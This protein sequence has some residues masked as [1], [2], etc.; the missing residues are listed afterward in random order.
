MDDA[1]NR[2]VGSNAQRERQD[3]DAGKY[4]ALAQRA[5]GVEKITPSGFEKA[6]NTSPTGCILS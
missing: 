5:Y 6:Q 4:K 1:E 3:C 2:G